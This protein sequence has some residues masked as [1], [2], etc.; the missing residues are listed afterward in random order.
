MSFVT[1]QSALPSSTEPHSTITFRRSFI[2]RPSRKR[3]D[4][5]KKFFPKCLPMPTKWR[6]CGE[7][8]VGRFGGKSRIPEMVRDCSVV[9]DHLPDF[10]KHPAR[11]TMLC[12]SLRTSSDVEV[13]VNQCD[14]NFD[15]K[16]LSHRRLSDQSTIGG[17]AP[18]QTLVESV[19]ALSIACTLGPKGRIFRADDSLAT[20][21][22][23]SS[24]SKLLG[25]KIEKLLP[26]IK[27]E[28]G[29]EEQHICA[30]GARGNFIPVTAKLMTDKDAD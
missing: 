26:A 24:M 17:S 30:V 10:E 7:K 21:L 25:T 2:P 12:N 18:W 6:S 15:G 3:P 9:H 22:G 11:R 13:N 19:D 20:L 16:E 8:I 1:P 28:N 14:L 5:L 29:R 4:N 27:L 23:Y